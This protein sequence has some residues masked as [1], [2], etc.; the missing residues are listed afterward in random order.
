MFVASYLPQESQ[1]RE[2]VLRENQTIAKRNVRRSKRM[3]SR[4]SDLWY[5][6]DFDFLRSFLLCFLFFNDLVSRS[7]GACGCASIR[8][9]LTDV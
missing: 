9:S 4:S 2:S 3:T 5:A 6:R 1:F 7:S 8:A